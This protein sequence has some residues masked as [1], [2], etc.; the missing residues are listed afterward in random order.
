MQVIE[1]ICRRAPTV[2]VVA[3]S[4]LPIITKHLG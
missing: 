4:D 2:M 3:P 1:T